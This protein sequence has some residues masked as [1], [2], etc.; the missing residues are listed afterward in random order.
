M[1]AAIFDASTK[2]LTL[3]NVP[4]PEPGPEEVLVHVKAPV[5]EPYVESEICNIRDDNVYIW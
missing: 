4:I 2:K 1:C 5:S 3:A